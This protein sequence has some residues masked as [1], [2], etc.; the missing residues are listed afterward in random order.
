MPRILRI[1]NRFNLGGPTFNVAY[2][3]KFM[4][5]D[6]ETLLV[7]GAKDE[8]EDSSEFIVNSLGLNPVIIPSM[9]RSVSPLAD[10]QAYRDIKKLIRDFKP[11]IVHTHASKA[12]AVGRLAAYHE[13]VPVIV[14]TFHGHVF[15]S[16]F[17]K[18][19][20]TVYKQIERYLARRSSAIVAIS[21][22]QKEELSTIHRICAPEKITVVPLGFD[23]SRFREQQAEKRK[24]FRQH[25]QVADDTLAVV[26]VGRLVP[27]KNHRL[28]LEAVAAA[29]KQTN[30][31]WKAFIVGDGESRA[32]LEAAARELQ[33]PFAH[34]P[35]D[36]LLT[37]TSWIREVDAVYA[38]ADV[39]ALSSWNE[40]TPVS[41]IEAQAA[42]RA[43]VTTDVGGISDVV[44]PGKTALLAPTG[45]TKAFTNNLVSLLNNDTQRADFGAAGWPHVKDKFHYTRLVRDMEQLYRKLLAERTR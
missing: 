22:K 28:F 33:L 14:H 10:Y 20:T 13:N 30:R 39:V 18:T 12:G 45:D 9:R 4:P 37:F 34:E 11:D 8:S 32:E 23:L 2:L 27:V 40:G 44:L 1:I 19:T 31:K 26:I 43:I 24:Q 35:G 29:A 17:G 5:P 25:W 15:H 38:G 42:G 7:G 3:S 41:L 21:E 16:Y 36:Q 6:F